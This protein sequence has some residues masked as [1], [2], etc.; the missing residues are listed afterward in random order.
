MK[1][2]GTPPF[3]EKA[4]ASV[5]GCGQ[6]TMS[7][8]TQMRCTHRSWG[9]EQQR[10]GGAGPR[11]RCV[12]DAVLLAGQQWG[13][14]GWGLGAGTSFF[15]VLMG[16]WVHPACGRMATVPTT[17]GAQRGDPPCVSTGKL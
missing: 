1:I 11:V 2:Q 15:P 10:L 5:W 7:R 8:G 14:G 6:G 4:K 9:D 17:H 16:S 3:G 12:H 13:R